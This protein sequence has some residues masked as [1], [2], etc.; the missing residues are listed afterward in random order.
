MIREKVVGMPIKKKNALPDKQNDFNLFSFIFF[1]NIVS[2]AAGMFVFGFIDNFI[3]VLAGETIDRT[4]ANAFGFSTM[5]SAGLGNAISDAAGVIMGS[6]V[7]KIVFHMF[8]EA[9]KTQY[10]N[11]LIIFVETVGIVLGCMVGMFP[12]LFM[13]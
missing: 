2:V 9:D 10:S 5:F 7:A 8:G 11:T 4:I 1:K 13:S 3:L 6:L 12:L